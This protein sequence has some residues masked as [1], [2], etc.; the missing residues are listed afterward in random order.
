MKYQWGSYNEWLLSERRG[1]P[2]S[3]FWTYSCGSLKY[4]V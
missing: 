3:I 4:Q 1:A 2:Q